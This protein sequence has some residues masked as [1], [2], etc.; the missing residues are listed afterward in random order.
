MQCRKVGIVTP[1]RKLAIALWRFVER[2]VF[3][4]RATSRLDIKRTEIRGLTARAASPASDR[5]RGWLYA[6]QQ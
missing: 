5:K 1:A 4:E 6:A 3:P 2:G